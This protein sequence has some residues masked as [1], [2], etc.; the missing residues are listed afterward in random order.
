MNDQ[1]YFFELNYTIQIGLMIAYFSLL[2][3]AIY[4][5][6][7]F[8]ICDNKNTQQFIEAEKQGPIGSK[9]YILSL[10]ESL[11]AD[12]LWPF[13]YISAAILTPISLYLMN[14]A[15]TVYHF[16]ILFLIS[17]MT[18]YFIFLYFAHHYIHFIKLTIIDYIKN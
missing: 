12:G 4:M 11:C 6:A 13:A 3:F 2:I 10:V 7:T 1:L 8:Y 9:K 14:I 5:L 16:A 15:I 18:I 17:F